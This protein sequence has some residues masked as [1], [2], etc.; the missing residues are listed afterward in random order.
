M[1]RADAFSRYL[2]AQAALPDKSREP[3]S[4][5][6]TISREA[7]AGGMAIA[8]LLAQHLTAAEKS[9][10]TSPWA[11]F[12]ANL[13]NPHRSQTVEERTQ[14]VLSNFTPLHSEPLPERLYSAKIS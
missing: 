5:A 11:V 7:G 6:I 10:A 8:E 9:P 2:Q 4:L 12:N 3:L 1:C 14:C 13:A